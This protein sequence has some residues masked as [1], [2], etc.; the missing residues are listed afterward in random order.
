M[1][2]LGGNQEKRRANV[3]VAG[4]WGSGFRDCPILD[5]EVGEG[6]E[7]LHI[8]TYKNS[9]MVKSY[10]GNEDIVRPYWSSL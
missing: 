8:M 7:L 10:G 6:A 2:L 4:K 3:P 5:H 1:L 9:S